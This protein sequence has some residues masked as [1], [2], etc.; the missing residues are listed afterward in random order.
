[1]KTASVGNLGRL[2]IRS[3]RPL[4]QAIATLEPDF[5]DIG[6][7]WRR[8]LAK[9]VRSPAQFD[10]L[11]AMAPHKVLENFPRDRFAGF[12][13]TLVSQGERLATENV[14]LEHAITASR[15]YLRLCLQALPRRN[16]ATR[17]MALSLVRL[18]SVG[19]LFLISGYTSFR[20]NRLHDVQ[21]DLAAA[22]DRLHSLTRIINNVYDQ[23]RRSIS[24][25]LHDEVGHD[26]I[27]LKLYLEM[28]GRDILERRDGKLRR[29]LDEAIELVCK[30][31]DRVRQL[32]F[33]LG[34]AISNELGFASALRLYVRQFAKRTGIRVRLR[35]SGLDG[36]GLPST[37]EMTLYRVMQGALS[38]VGRHSMA[39]SVEI[40]LARRKDRV[41]MTITDNGTGFSVKRVL[42]RNRAFG[43]MTM[44]ERVELLGGEF[45]IDSAPRS[46]AGRARGTTI[47]VALPVFAVQP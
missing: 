5:E 13:R 26:L 8:G 20:A 9:L 1:V 16:A 41:Q 36:A 4:L 38:N 2:V 11:A 15:D 10:A 25:D 33:D 22:E 31:I 19:Q 3:T 40:S 17:A 18:T 45:R 39:T 32:S 24:R 28:I 35:T 29:R 7:R 46:R 43:V 47:H 44:R 37:H 6:A 34:P 23:E 42:G 27:V 30:A 14:A 21:E 12:R